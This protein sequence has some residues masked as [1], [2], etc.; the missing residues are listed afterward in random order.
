MI[1][2]TCDFG[3]FDQP[4]FVSAAEQLVIRSGGGV[5]AVLTTTQAVYSSYNE[6]LDTQYLHAQFT[7]NEDG[8]W[9]TFG[10]S[11]R[12]GKNAT[13]ITSEN[14]DELA[15]FRKFSLLGDPMLTPDF[16]V[17]KIQMDSVTDGYTMQHADTINALGAYIAHGSVRDIS[18]NLLTGFTGILSV[19]FFDKPQTITT[20]SGTNEKFQLQNN[21][22]YKGRVSVTN[23]LFS[24]TF[25]APKDIAYYYGSGKIST[26]ATDGVTDAAGVNTSTQVGGFSAH[27]QYNSNPPIVKAYINDSLFQN[28]GITGSNTSLFVSLFDE[29]GINVAGNNVGHDLTAVLDGSTETP[30]I[31]NDYYETAPNTY[32]RGYITFPITGL[33]DGRHSITV[34]AWDVNDNVGEGT[35]DFTVV[36]GNVMD[37]QNLGNYPNPFNNL[38]HFV[39]DHNHPDEQLNVKI[40]IYNTSGALVKNIA[41]DFTPSGSRSNEITWDGTGNNGARLSSGVYVY[42]LSISTDKGFRSVAYQKLVIVR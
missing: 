39:F 37:I 8:T 40:D 29:T 14:S 33:T 15:N 34:K 9:N 20:I 25:I 4:S 26:Y 30:Y 16:P 3:Q 22:V 21:L 13:Y 10:G 17:N 35:V 18:G 28:G 2:A 11:V 36:D 6:E 12:L 24:F 27:P 1:T 5:I 19:S 23:G 31:L 32:Q 7:R 38:T 41:Q 42:R